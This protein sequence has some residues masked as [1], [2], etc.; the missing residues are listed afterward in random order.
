MPVVT[1]VVALLAGLVAGAAS[2]PLIFARAV[3]RG[4]PNRRACPTCAAAYPSPGLGGWLRATTGRCPSCHEKI[5]PAAGLAEVL[6]G[7]AF[8]A[9]GAAGATG[10]VG[11][12]QYW[13]LACGAVL[14]VIDLMVHRLPDVLT[15]PVSAGTLLLLCG[16]GL[17]GEPG[18]IG[19]VFTAAAVVT[20]FYLVL[21]LA[22]MGMGDVK[23][24]PAVGALLGWSSWA[25]VFRGVFAGF[26]LAA[27]IALVL[28]LTGKATRKSHLAFGPYMVVGALAVSALSS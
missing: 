13:L 17:S 22:G 10:W 16:A 24:G 7:A 15:F 5:G 1:V 2:R 4:E 19:R 6:T 28:M 18:S 23:L 8:A 21:V 3:P 11:A 20:A 12:A 14:T 27:A 26:V 25:A 9:L